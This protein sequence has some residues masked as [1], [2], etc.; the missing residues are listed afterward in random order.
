[1]EKLAIGISNHIKTSKHCS[2]VIKI[3]RVSFDDLQFFMSLSDVLVSPEKKNLL[4]DLVLHIKYYNYL[5]F[6]KPIICS[7]SDAVKKFNKDDR[8]SITFDP[9]SISDLANK[10]QYSY[11]NFEMLRD[12]YSSNLDSLNNLSYAHNTMAIDSPYNLN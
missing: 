1:M 12:K 9:G 3:N 7:R 5:T 11:D 8:Y 4:S 2:S 10:I 6:N